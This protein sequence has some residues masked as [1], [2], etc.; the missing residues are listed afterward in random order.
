MRDAHICEHCNLHLP[1]G[2]RHCPSCRQ[3]LVLGSR[4]RIAIW[5][6]GN[7]RDG[8]LGPLAKGLREAFRREV[9]IQ[10]TFIDERPSLRP[11]W[12]GRSA[13]VF[14]GQ[15]LRRHRPGTW[16]NLGV[17]ED[18]IVPSSAYNFLFGLAY[19]GSPAAIV[20]L[21][22]MGTDKPSGELLA[23]RALNIAIHELGHTRGLDHHAY[24]DRIDC[25]MVG[26][27][28][29]DSRETI[30]SGTARFCAACRRAMQ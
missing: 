25:V 17:T 19:M 15:V 7:I 6:L 29:M 11:D 21:H 8:V 12:P 24:E 22:E 28:A 5:R 27:E 13:S 4:G 16:A 23:R 14:L 10:P 2:S 20:S 1:L 30:D 18:N 9:V 26:D 3:P